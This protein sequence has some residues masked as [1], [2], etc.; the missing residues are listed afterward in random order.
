MK[1]RQ[2]RKI[3]MIIFTRWDRRR[4]YCPKWKR[5]SLMIAARRSYRA[6]DWYWL[7]INTSVPGYAFEGEPARRMWA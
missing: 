1:L 4:V 3:L 2:A 5:R 6:G 7:H